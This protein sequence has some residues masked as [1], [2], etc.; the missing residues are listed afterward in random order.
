MVQRFDLTEAGVTHLGR[1]VETHKFL[2][3]EEAGRMIYSGFGTPVDRAEPTP[4]R[5]EESNPA[6]INIV[7]F[8]DEYLALWE[9]GRPYR[10][11]P[12]TLATL[13]TA[14][15]ME[16]RPP[17]PSSAHP[18]IDR[19]GNLWNFGIDPLNDRLTV[20]RVSLAGKVDWTCDIA[21]KQVAPAHDFAVTQR[22]LVFLLP[23]ITCNV[24]R[25]VKGA[26]FAESCQWSPELG[27]RVLVVNKADGQ[28]R[29]YELPPG[30][31]FHVA[32]AWEDDGTIHVHYMRADDPSSLVAGWTL[33]A[34]EYRHSRGAA[35]THARFDTSTG[36]AVQEI[37]FDHDAEFPSLLAA[38]VGRRHDYL[39]CLERTPA[40]PSNV[41]GYDQ[42]AL[43]NLRSGSRRS[44]TYGDEWMVEEHLII[45]AEGS[46]LP[47]WA[48][49]VALNLRE[50]VTAITVFEL[51]E[52]R[53]ARLAEARLPYPLP[54][55]LHGIFVNAEARV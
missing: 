8:N 5:I 7:R 22:H 48:I 51:G 46:S 18:K 50:R 25:L 29:T 36:R 6:N 41:P 33:M 30:C 45:A 15:W 23:S 11:D 1:F 47:R 20:Y 34:G 35:L 38:D 42:F 14:S 55:G 24:D 27:M 13:G 16:G 10:F 12:R 17:G 28:T 53:V 49:G 19:D 39:L 2:A 3:E 4:Q 54:L 52:E 32:N 40:R 43:M 21:V 9:A 26:S 37:V 44:Y 31:L